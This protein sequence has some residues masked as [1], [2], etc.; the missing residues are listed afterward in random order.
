MK[1]H[2]NVIIGVCSPLFYFFVSFCLLIMEY[3]EKYAFFQNALIIILPALPGIALAFL[4]IRDTFKDFLKSLGVCFLTSVFFIII[5]TVCRIELMLYTIATGYD[6]F[7]LGEG[8]L[9]AITSTVYLIS[10]SA[11]VVI[12]GIITFVRQ[13]LHINKIDGA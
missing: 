7:A 10:C 1:K 5:V 13:K 3:N 12:S 8:F 2:T 9:Y 6:E 11:G 4:L